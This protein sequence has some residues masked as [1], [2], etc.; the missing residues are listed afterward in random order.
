MGL[1]DHVEAR[2][3]GGGSRSAL[4][5]RIVADV[6]GLRVASTATAEGAAFGAAILATVGVGWDRNV[7]DAVARLVRTVAVDETSDP[8]AY[9]D[10]YERYRSLY[11][12]LAPTFHATP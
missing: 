11:P 12:A 10:A 3:T 4:W 9:T 1:T 7:D 5:R 2:I 8:G 6:L